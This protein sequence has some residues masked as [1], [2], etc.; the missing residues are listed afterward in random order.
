MSNGSGYS[1]DRASGSRTQ[2]AGGRLSCRALV[3]EPRFE[4]VAVPQLI[5]RNTAARGVVQFIKQA[6]GAQPSFTI[7]QAVAEG[8]GGAVAPAA[9]E[10]ALHGNAE[11]ALGSAR[12]TLAQ[13]PPRQLAQ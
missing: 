6:V 10:P 9:R 7:K 13:M 1:G 11:A 8:G 12:H 5:R 2:E 3:S 4:D